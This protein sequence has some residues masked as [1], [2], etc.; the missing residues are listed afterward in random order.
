MY[1]EQQD[2]WTMSAAERHVCAMEL[3]PN[4][5][6]G[7]VLRVIGG[8]LWLMT[9]KELEEADKLATTEDQKDAMKLLRKWVMESR[10]LW[11]RT[12]ERAR[13]VSGN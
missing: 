3:A 4:F 12:Q 10:D 9:D 7:D 1:D 8:L 11:R 2:P 13:A 5:L 6:A